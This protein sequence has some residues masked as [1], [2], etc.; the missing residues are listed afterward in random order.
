M[1][2]NKIKFKKNKEEKIKKPVRIRQIRITDNE[3]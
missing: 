3:T 2:K 1:F